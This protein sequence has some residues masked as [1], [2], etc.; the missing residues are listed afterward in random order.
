[1][2]KPSFIT[3]LIFAL[4]LGVA[5]ASSEPSLPFED[6]RWNGAIKFDL[7]GSSFLECWASTSFADGTTLKLTKRSGGSWHLQLSNP[8]WRLP[9]SRQFD[10]VTIVDFYPERIQATAQIRN[11]TSFEIENLDQISLLQLI[12]N[13]H[14]IKFTA[15]EFTESY[16]LEGSAK[17][18]QRIQNCYADHN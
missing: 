16:N 10:V 15:D 14:L 9:P 5:H 6:G 8:D 11:Q 3:S 1:M 13:G 7:D 17:V 4:Q 2:Y 12:E 18:I